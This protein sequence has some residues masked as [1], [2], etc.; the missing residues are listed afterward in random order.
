MEELKRREKLVEDVLTEYS[1]DNPLL[2]DKN[3]NR[4]C[5]GLL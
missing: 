2:T 5:E 4:Y 1:K 3:Y